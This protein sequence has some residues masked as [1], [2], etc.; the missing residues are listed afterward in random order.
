MQKPSPDGNRVFRPGEETH[1]AFNQVV[2]ASLAEYMKAWLVGV[3]REM[4]KLGYGFVPGVGWTG[5][6]LTIH[7][8]LVGLFPAGERGEEAASVV[9]GVASETWTRF[10]GRS[11]PLGRV[12]AVPGFAEAKKWTSAGG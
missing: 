5:L 12:S 1:K 2:Q 4:D 7:D 9:A 10:F 8:S 6:V 11:D 3:Q